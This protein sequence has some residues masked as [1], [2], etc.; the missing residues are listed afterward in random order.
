MQKTQ[1]INI[2]KRFST[3]LTAL[4]VWLALGTVS[5]SAQQVTEDAEE[6]KARQAVQAKFSKNAAISCA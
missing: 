3:V 4:T 1:R 6:T 2:M 5:V